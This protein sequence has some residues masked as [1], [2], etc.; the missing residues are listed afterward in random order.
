MWLLRLH[1]LPTPSP[2]RLSVPAGSAPS[3]PPQLLQHHQIGT[4]SSKPSIITSEVGGCLHQHTQTGHAASDLPHSCW[5]ASHRHSGQVSPAWPR[6]LGPV[7]GHQQAPELW[8][9]SCPFPPRAH[10]LRSWAGSRAW[11]HPRGSGKAG[12]PCAPGKL[13]GGEGKMEL[14]PLCDCSKGKGELPSPLGHAQ[15]R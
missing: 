14:F 4:S 11:S 13:R 5:E 8:Q 2:L 12:F 3:A 1:V 10:P 7:W 6:S 9:Q 15:G